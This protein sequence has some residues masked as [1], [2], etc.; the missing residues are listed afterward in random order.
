MRL[1][2]RA[3]EACAVRR[4]SDEVG[5]GVAG[6][7]RR[8][9]E[10]S[11]LLLPPSPPLPGTPPGTKVPTSAGSTSQLPTGSAMTWGV[12]SDGSS[13][14]D[15]RS[16]AVTNAQNQWQVSVAPGRRGPVIFLKVTK[17]GFHFV[18]MRPVGGH[19]R[20]EG[21]SVF[22][23]WAGDGYALG[24]S[25]PCQRGPNTSR[26]EGESIVY[27]S[28]KEALCLFKFKNKI[29]ILLPIW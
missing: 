17:C 15:H 14:T 20:Q 26:P 5:N 4:K 22:P 19:S 9:P 23:R 10:A 7:D 12:G 11:S 28:Q 27:S 2:G 24:P 29:L 25:C 1:E 18:G 6:A 8:P 13:M 3:E 21:P 16:L